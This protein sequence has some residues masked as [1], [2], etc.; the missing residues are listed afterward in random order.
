MKLLVVFVIFLI[1][2]F[3]S[4]VCKKV[5]KEGYRENNVNKEKLTNDFWKY[6]NNS[7]KNS[8][9]NNLNN[10]IDDAI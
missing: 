8:V 2:V 7:V 1:L 3:L 5:T 10:N 4:L 6:L 9:E